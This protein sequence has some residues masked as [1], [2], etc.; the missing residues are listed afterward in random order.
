PGHLVRVPQRD[1]T[2]TQGSAEEREPRQPEPEDVRVPVREKRVKR[3]APQREQDTSDDQ[4][5]T[6]D[7]GKTCSGSTTFRLRLRRRGPIPLGGPLH[8]PSGYATPRR[9]RASADTLW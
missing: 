2:G 3:E 8:F 1:V 6:G 5:G 7:R 9:F 4:E